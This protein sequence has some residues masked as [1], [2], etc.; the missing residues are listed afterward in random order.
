[1]S[2]AKRPGGQVP[3]GV[4]VGERGD[5]AGELETIVC[6]SRAE[7]ADRCDAHHAATA[8]AVVERPIDGAGAGREE[9]RDA[10][11][12]GGSPMVKAIDRDEPAVGIARPAAASL[13]L[14]GEPPRVGVVDDARHVADPLA[15]A[16]VVD[17]LDRGGD[18]RAPG[19]GHLEP[20]QE[21]APFDP[22]EVGDRASAAEV[23]H[24]RV[25]A[26]LEHRAVLDQVQPETSELALLSDVDREAR[27][28]ARGFSARRRRAGRR[29]GRGALPH[30]R[31]PQ[32]S[33]FFRLRSNPACNM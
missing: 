30:R 25:D 12:A 21:P 29:A 28:P 27:S 1:M 8:L 23:D 15:R 19:L 10:G 13:P 9:R 33:S 11:G 4:A 32:T 16:E 31:A 3:G 18:V 17:Q 6:V 22:E 5:V 2:S 26:A 24:G 20:L 7:Q 14:S